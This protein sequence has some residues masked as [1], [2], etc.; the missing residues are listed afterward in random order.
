MSEHRT[1]LPAALINRPGADAAP[2]HLLI[3]G[4][5]SRLG[6]AL[7][8]LALTAGIPVTA[9]TRDPMR[10]G[11]A[12]P[13]LD[14]AVECRDFRPPPGVDAAVLCAA[15]TDLRGCAD[16][17]DLARRTNHDAPLAIAAACRAAGVFVVFPSTNLVFD[18][19]RPFRRAGEAPCPLTPYGRLKA[20]TEAALLAVGGAAV[21]RLTKVL[22]PDLPLLA[23]W[24]A[25]LQAGERV[26]AFHDMVLA[27]V[28]L[29]AAAAALLAAAAARRPGI[30]HLSGRSDLSYEILARTIAA[31]LG[32]GPERVTAVSRQEA[33]IAD[34]AAPAHTTLAMDGLA[35]DLGLEPAD[36]GRVALF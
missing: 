30:V 18:G 33:G 15:V 14:L 28:G 12:T 4:G 8:A 9:T 35:A 6:R 17:P 16:A 24:T 26:R 31:R 1:P 22:A 21:V 10:S 13:F 7:A 34:A 25:A 3:V 19:T 11:P 20:E 29:G 5:D 2:R 32:V 36:L 27:P 23:G